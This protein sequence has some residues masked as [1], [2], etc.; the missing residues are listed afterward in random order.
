MN[1]ARDNRVWC[2]FNHARTNKAFSERH[3]GIL[4]HV[5]FSRKIG[6]FRLSFVQTARRSFVTNDGPLSFHGAPEPEEHRG[7]WWDCRFAACAFSPVPARPGVPG[8][9]GKVQ[10]GNLC[11]L[12]S[13]PSKGRCLVPPTSGYPYKPRRPSR[14][15]GLPARTGGRP[16]AVRRLVK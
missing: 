4:Q 13:V 6:T 3:P 7:R 8:Q 2:L 12:K 11:G 1:L 9:G 10:A 5:P 14:P 15:G 16:Q